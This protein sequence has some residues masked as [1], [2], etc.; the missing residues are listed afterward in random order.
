MDAANISAS[1]LLHYSCATTLSCG[2]EAAP[3]CLEVTHAKHAAAASLTSLFLLAALFLPR[4]LA[5]SC[6]Q[7]LQDDQVG[8]ASHT[9]RNTLPT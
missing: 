5:R 8:T 3:L 1:L 4:R 7:L 9:L 6:E 2:L